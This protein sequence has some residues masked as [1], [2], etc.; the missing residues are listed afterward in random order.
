MKQT[1]IVPPSLKEF[2]ASDNPF[3]G[4]VVVEKFHAAEGSNGSSI[5]TT[6]I[7]PIISTMIPVI[8][9]AGA[10]ESLA[11]ILNCQ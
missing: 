7:S 8:G 1:V 10:A 5:I 11:V 9:K 3:N 6:Y 2:F 4:T